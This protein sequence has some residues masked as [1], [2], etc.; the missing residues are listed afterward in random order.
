MGDQ[1]MGFWGGFQ[2]RKGE[3]VSERDDADDESLYTHAKWFWC[4]LYH[5]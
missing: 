2:R 4:F 3:R 5:V 1:S